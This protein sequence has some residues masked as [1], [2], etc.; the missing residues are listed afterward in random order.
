[1]K[2]KITITRALTEIK[3]LEDRVRKARS[4]FAGMA[5]KIG[6]KLNSPYSDI[7]P[8]DFETK[9]TSTLQKIEALQNNVIAIKKAINDSN[10][11]TKIKIGDSEM[12]IAEALVMKTKGLVMKEE[13]LEVLRLHYTQR[14]N[15]FNRAIDKYQAKVDEAPKSFPDKKPEEIKQII[16]LTLKPNEPKLV[17]PCNLSEYIEKLE[18]EISTFKNNIDYV[19][20]E[21]NSTTYVEVDDIED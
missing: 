6:D 5:V 4:S 11:V 15:D 7:K 19:L 20:S 9:A 17:D 8:E 16:E 10:Y 3:T 12:T 2:K 14:I 1:M 21:S 18:A 13:L